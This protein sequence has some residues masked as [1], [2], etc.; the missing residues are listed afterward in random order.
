MSEIQNHTSFCIE[1]FFQQY[2]FHI[3]TSEQPVPGS[4]QN[5]SRTAGSDQAEYG[6]A[7]LL[8]YSFADIRS[9]TFRS[10]YSFH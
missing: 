2:S 1:A 3:N 8:R 4:F 5:S 7:F 6:T 9:D 10:Q